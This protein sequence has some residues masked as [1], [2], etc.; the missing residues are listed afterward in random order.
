MN[1]M[2]KMKWAGIALSA[3]FAIGFAPKA[4]AVLVLQYET[5]PQAGQLFQTGGISIKLSGVTAGTLYQNIPVNSTLGVTENP[6]GLGVTTMNAVPLQTPPVG[7]T[8]PG[9]DT[10]GIFT[11]TGIF[12]LADPVNALWTPAGKGQ[13]IT[14]I[15][16]GGKDF[17][18][19]QT[20]LNTQSIDSVGL[21][22][23]FYLDTTPDYTVGA[24]GAR[25]GNTYPTV[26]D[27]TLILS[28]IA[29]AGFIHPVGEDGGLATAAN[30]SF[31]GAAGGQGQTFLDVTGGAD[32]NM[33]NTNSILSQF[34]PGLVTDIQANFTTS[35]IAVPA[36]GWVARVNDPLTTEVIP[37]PATTL[38]GLACMIPLL[39][40]VLRR[41]RQVTA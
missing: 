20:S 41:R 19:K 31:N 21:Q 11:I 26:T 4:Q 15:F 23:D 8:I 13:E 10:W 35:T 34:V 18:L 25:V 38:A 12:S 30:S 7:S 27:G 9:E 33:F 14:A 3:L 24:A 17:F 28:T 40:S 6:A 16:Y 36:G 39:G 37:E 2:N 32:V 29:K 22:A 1:K 5:G